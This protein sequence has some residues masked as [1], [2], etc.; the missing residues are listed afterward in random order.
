MHGSNPGPPRLQTSH[1]FASARIRSR[2]RNLDRIPAKKVEEE[3]LQTIQEIKEKVEKYE[4]EKKSMIQAE[5]MRK[6]SSMTTS[7]S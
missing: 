7:S 3:L 2:S 5:K 4:G 1:F 6:S